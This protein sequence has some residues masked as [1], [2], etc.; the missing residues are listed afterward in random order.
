LPARPAGSQSAREAEG[1]PDRQSRQRQRRETR[2]SGPFTSANGLEEGVSV[3]GIY[4][5]D[6]VGTSQTNTGCAPG[7]ML[8]NST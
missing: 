2:T 1:Q 7:L 8:L 3:P 6:F 4:E 5:L